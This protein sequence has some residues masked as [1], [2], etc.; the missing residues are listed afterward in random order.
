MLLLNFKIHNPKF[1]DWIG[2]E[3]D[4]IGDLK[5][6]SYKEIQFNSIGFL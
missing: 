1:K 2:N 5:Y 3:L 4:L 6:N